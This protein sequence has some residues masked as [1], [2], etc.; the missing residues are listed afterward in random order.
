[1]DESVFNPQSKLKR[2]GP[3]Y[4]PLALVLIFLV[5]VLAMS[6]FFRVSEIEVV[7]ASDY[8]D[9]EIITASGIEKGVNLFFVDRFSAASMIFADLPYMDTV[10]IRRQLPN[11]I[12]FLDR[13]GRALGVTTALKAEP[14]PEIR[15]LQTITVI[16]GEDPVVE[17][18]NIERLKYAGDLLNALGGQGL[19]GKVSWID[20]KDPANP[21]IYYD[22]R[23]TVYFGEREN[24]PFKAALLE[25]ALTKLAADDSGSLAYGGGSAWTFSPD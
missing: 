19:I 18:E 11:R 24:T 17:G 23:L 10:S 15:S 25:D 7:N 4:G 16:P 1:M 3:L 5:V 21:S 12:W 22:G 2:T 6:L 14:Y 13:N 8:T 20:L 9:S